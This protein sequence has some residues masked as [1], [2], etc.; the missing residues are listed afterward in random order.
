MFQILDRTRVDRMKRAYTTRR[1]PRDAIHGL[2]HGG[3]PVSGDLVVAQVI[4]IGQHKRLEAPDG[5]KQSLFPGDEILLCFA[6]R[7][8]PAQFEAVV[9]DRL[10]PCDLVAAGGVAARAL[11]WHVEKDEPTRIDVLGFVTDEDGDRVNLAHHAAP[12]PPP[13]TDRPWTIVIAGTS[14]DSGKTTTAAGI[15]RGLVAA[16]RSVGAAKVTG[17]GAGGDVWLMTDAGAAPVLD[18]TDSGMASTYLMEDDRILDSFVKLH[19]QLCAA[20]IDVAVIEVADGLYH[21]E[22]RS[23]LASDPLRQR[24]DAIVFAA[25]DAAG[26]VAG[27]EQLRSMDLPVVAVSGLL[28]ASP[29]ATREARCA[30]DLPVLDL[31]QLWAADHRLVAPDTID[32]LVDHRESL[33]PTRPGHPGR[34]LVAASAS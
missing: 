1:I 11:S 27:V 12:T 20:P 9:P 26:A 13:S 17:T 19:R 28:T 31:E 30:L 2:T 5:R 25:G 34:S 14:M 23:L 22:T 3:A 8:A 7:Y 24:C 10:G 15:I 4:E 18:F 6:N 29:L 32:A 16:G 21:D 33:H